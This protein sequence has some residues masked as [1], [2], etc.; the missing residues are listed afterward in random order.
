MSDPMISVENLG[1]RYTLRHQAAKRYSTLRDSVAGLWARAAAR[2]GQESHEE[3]WALHEVSF[4]MPRGEVLGIIG[5]NGAGKSTLLKILS[6]ITE[7]SQGRVTLDGRVASLLEVGTG[8]HPELTGRENIHLNGAILGMTRKEINASFDEIV[9]F[10]EVD[11]FLDTPVKRYSSGMYVR[12]AFS[13]AAHLR[14]EILVVDEVLAV[15]DAQFQAKCLG[16]ME[17]VSRQ[18]GRTILFVSHQMSAVRRL[19]SSVLWL[20]R[21]RVVEHSRDVEDTVQ[22]YLRGGQDSS[23]QLP[24]RV[25]LQST[26]RDKGSASIFAAV[27]VE[28]TRHAVTAAIFEPDEDMIISIECDLRG[29]T[30]DSLTFSIQLG[31]IGGERMATWFYGDSTGHEL[32]SSGTFV[33]RCKVPALH[34]A[35]GDYWIGVGAGQRGDPLDKV[36]EALMLRIESRETTRAG[37]LQAPATWEVMSS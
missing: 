20:D 27:G 32:P 10:A 25:D 4:E 14:P 2:Q 12:L 24:A 15:G 35:P 13:V 3:F 22:R 19:C 18:S 21:G 28:S 37:L 36:N 8:F 29:Q 9:A 5:R 7:P 6:R 16:K 23:E 33:C 30:R 17:S 26:P 1:K 34:L 31:S 11:R